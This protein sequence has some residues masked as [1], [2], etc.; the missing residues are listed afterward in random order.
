MWQSDCL[1][2]PRVLWEGKM[3]KT[4]LFAFIDDM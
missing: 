1:H 4:Y 3:K 2:G